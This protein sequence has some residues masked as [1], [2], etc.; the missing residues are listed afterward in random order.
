[1]SLSPL[2]EA[3]GDLSSQDPASKP[4]LVAKDLSLHGTCSF[5]L[6]WDSQRACLQVTSTRCHG[7]N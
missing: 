7:L 6:K 2:A 5:H 4:H 1:M 3:W